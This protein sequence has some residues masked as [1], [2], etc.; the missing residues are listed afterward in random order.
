[1][2]TV[3]ARLGT[4]AA[5]AKWIQSLPQTDDDG[6]EAVQYLACDVP[7][8]LRLFPRDPNCFERTFAALTLLEVV[9]A[10]TERMAVTIER[11]ARHTGVVEMRGGHWVALDLF[12]RRNFDW[13]NFGKDVLHGVHQYVGKP[14]LKFYGLGSVGDT[15]GDVEDKAVGYKTNEKKEAPPSESQPGAVGAGAAK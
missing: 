15:L 10:K 8:R 9:D 1:M 11:P 13:G 5:V 6:A 3:A 12:P 4:P 14:V 7:Q 2:R